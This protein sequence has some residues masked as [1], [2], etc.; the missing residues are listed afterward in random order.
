MIN[1]VEDLHQHFRILLH[2]VDDLIPL[3]LRDGSR[4]YIHGLRTTWLYSSDLSLG[5]CEGFVAASYPW[6]MGGFS[7]LLRLSGGRRDLRTVLVVE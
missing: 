7:L 6:G 4:S 5:K 2:V 3:I 1:H